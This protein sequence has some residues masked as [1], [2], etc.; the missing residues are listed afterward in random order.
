M[1]HRSQDK[2]QG[3]AKDQKLA[4]AQLQS[5][6]QLGLLG[7]EIRGFASAWGG[8]DPIAPSR[9]SHSFSSSQPANRSKLEHSIAAIGDSGG[10]SF[11]EKGELSSSSSSLPS[12]PGVGRLRAPVRDASVA[13]QTY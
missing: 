11:P 5:L 4:D 3:F 7:P 1:F 8:T 10:P 12:S 6:R 9:P 2:Q 13:G